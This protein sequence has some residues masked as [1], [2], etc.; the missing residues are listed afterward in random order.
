ML[1]SCPINYFGDEKYYR[2]HTN[3]VLANSIEM[4]LIIFRIFENFYI[5]LIKYFNKKIFNKKIYTNYI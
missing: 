5:Y 3:P 1:Y 4:N 2:I